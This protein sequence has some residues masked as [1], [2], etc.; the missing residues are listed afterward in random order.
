MDN[1]TIREATTK[2]FN[3]ILDLSIQLYKAEQPFDSNIKDGYYETKE[4]KKDL[5]K[6]I[7]DKKRYFLV[8]IYDNKI[9]G[10][11]DGYIYDKD[12][13]KDKIAY[14]D[15]LSVDKEY[16]GKGFGSALIDAFSNEVKKKDVKF[17]KLNA[18]EGNIP[19]V[20]LYKKKEFKEYSVF[21]MKKI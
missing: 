20:S 15:R 18:F 9:V 5:L 11:I 10:Y 8:G 21:Y 17:I 4:G 16:R 13:Y 19:A 3:R 6:D 14:L 1:L 7:K 12:V 2:D